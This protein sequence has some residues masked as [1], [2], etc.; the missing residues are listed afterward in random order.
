MKKQLKVILVVGIIAL[1]SIGSAV[2][3]VAASYHISESKAK[4]IALNRAN[5]SKSS[6]KKWTKTKLDKSDREWDIEFR[7]AN[8][9]YEVEINSH[10]GRVKDFDKDRISTAKTISRTKAKSLALKAV[11]VSSKN[12]KTWVKVKH[13]IGDREWDLEFK[14][15]NYKYE[16]ELHDRTGA[17]LDTEKKA[18]P[19]Q[20]TNYIG[21]DKAKAIA[22]E[23]AKQNSTINGDVTYTKAK[24][25]RDD[26]VACYDIEFIYNGY[27]YEYEINAVSGNIMEW[28]ID[29]D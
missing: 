26:G 18:L 19:K 25:D 11:H 13:D 17:I 21:L 29:I 24:L 1:L 22:L 3:V 4:S 6:V 14:T 12:V 10:T 16:V 2:S 15:A 23:H 7:T 9:K 20:S 5:V 27:E 28:D 8:Y